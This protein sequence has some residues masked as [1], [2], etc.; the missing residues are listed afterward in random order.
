LQGCITKALLESNQSIGQ[1]VDGTFWGSD[2]LWRCG[3]EHRGPEGSCSQSQII[4]NCADW[5]RQFLE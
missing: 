5:S 2:G 4:G 1:F 3:F